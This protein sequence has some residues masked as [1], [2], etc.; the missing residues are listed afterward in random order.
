ML[1]G[2]NLD[3]ELGDGTTKSSPAPVVAMD[4]GATD[5]CTGGNHTCATTEDG[6][7]LCWGL[8]TSGELG[9][10]VDH[11]LVPEAVQGL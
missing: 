10:P 8:G 3:G 5:V 4:A 2:D 9:A 6:R 7:V 11:E 1:P